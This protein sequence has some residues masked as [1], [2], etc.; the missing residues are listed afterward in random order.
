MANAFHNLKLLVNPNKKDLSERMS[1]AE[2]G[3]YSRHRKLSAITPG[4]TAPSLGKDFKLV[5]P[6]MTSVVNEMLG[7]DKCSLVV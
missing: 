7:A 5:L 3:N 6:S 2:E 4:A 1:F